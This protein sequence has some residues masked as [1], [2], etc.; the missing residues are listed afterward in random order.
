MDADFSV[1]CILPPYNV[2][3][4]QTINA[5]GVLVGGDTG[6][7]LTYQAVADP[8]GSINRTSIGKCNF[9]Q[10]VDPLFWI[11]VAPDVG[12][13]IPGPN[14]FAMPGVNNVPQAMTYDATAA[15]FGAFGIPL[16]PYD[17]AG[18]TNRYPMMRLVASSG[19][20]QVGF[21]DIVLPVAEEMN[22]RACHGSGAGS[23]AQP[24]DGWVNLT[25]RERD[26]R[27]NILRLHDDLQ[28]G[29]PI[30]TT[31]LVDGRYN[32]AGLYATVVAD[33]KPVLCASCHRS[34]ALPGSGHAGIPPLTASIHTQHGSVIDP[35]N[36]LLLDAEANRTSCYYC[37]PGQQTRCLR[38]I[39]GT[40]VAANGQ[41]E[42]ECQ[43][44]H[45]SMNLIGAATRTGWLNEPNC[46]ACHSGD[47]VANAGQ[48][49]Y[50]S[51]FS[52]PNVMRVSANQRF[53]TTPNTPAAGYSLYRF[54]RGHGGLYCE[55]CHN[56]TH[57]EFPSIDTNDNITCIQHQGYI[58][59]LAQ[60]ESCHHTQPSTVNGG[61]HGLHPMGQTWVSQH[62][63]NAGSACQVCHGTDYRGTVLSRMRTDRTLSGNGTKTFWRGYQVGC[64]SC[65]NGPGG[66]GSAPAPA[67]V[68]SRTATTTAGTSVA[69]P[70]TATGTGTLT[71][72]VVSQS[73]HG[74]VGLSGTAATYFPDPGFTGTDSFTFAALN[75]SND[76]NLG[77]VTITVTAGGGCTYT[78]TPTSASV[79]AGAG[80]GSVSIS[81]SA[82]CTW[83]ASS[84]ATWLTITSTTSGTGP[85]TVTYAFAANTT[86]SAR[87]GSLTIAGRTY[88]LTQ[89]AAA[90][91]VY[92]LTPTSASVSAGIG[93]GSVSVSAG[94][95]CPWT[96]SSGATWLTI[97]AGASG[98]GP[99]TVSYSIAANTDSGG[100]ITP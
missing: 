42:M 78:I 5:S 29:T 64:Y 76:S 43:S 31:A 37:H 39:M 93:S 6:V 53:A 75:G 22:C 90:S 33:G 32:A 4:A 7:G 89:D 19:G 25:D 77:L 40:S 48:I 24:A 97:T 34:E 54:S 47:A 50:T 81:T 30:F 57:A 18:R 8:S 55:A 59:P 79:G 99:G 44:C 60:C 35:A 65:H 61:P 3:N 72:R 86:S 36:G 62:Q 66:S 68:T 69:I 17:D 56:S 28:L 95:S 63:N 23:T 88:T 52:S 73:T 11:A 96:A 38:G 51:V 67:V 82:N 13:P 49:R 12:L 71:L 85:G 91:C 20:A 15:W 14:G 9:W 87:S 83:T 74:K 26:Y 84:G 98:T 10:F 21:T 70:L 80:S 94:A 45:G 46:Q 100:V 58:G 27:L 41:L 2:I 1:F 16:T 92:T